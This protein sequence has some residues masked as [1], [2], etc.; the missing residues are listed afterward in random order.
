MKTSWI[1]MQKTEDFLLAKGS[2][3]DRMI[4]KVKLLLDP[5][6]EEDVKHQKAAYTIIH[7]YGRRKLLEE[8]ELAAQNVFTLPKY[9]SFR[10][11]IRNIF[12]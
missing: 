4:Y 5:A 10:E 7:E 12:K 11:K 8:I 2:Q 3:E 9:I 1:E 6:L